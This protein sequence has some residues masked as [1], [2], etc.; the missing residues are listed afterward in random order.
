[1]KRSHDNDKHRLRDITSFF[2][3]SAS[4]SM[5]NK[6]SSMPTATGDCVPEKSAKVS[7]FLNNFSIVLIVAS[8]VGN[9]MSTV[10]RA[11]FPTFWCQA[12]QAVS[13]CRYQSYQFHKIILLQCSSSHQHSSLYNI[14][15]LWVKPTRV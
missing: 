2:T 9:D 15:F 3:T 13:R 1:M 4:S 5:E 14:L 12:L 6:H 8:Q 10:D 7:Y 11:N